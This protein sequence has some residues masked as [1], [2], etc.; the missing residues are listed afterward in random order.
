M[1]LRLGK[2][3]IRLTCAE[4]S[5]DHPGLEMIYLLGTFGTV[6]NG[7][8]VS[9]T[10]APQCLKFGDWC[11]Q[12]LAFYSGNASYSQ[13]IQPSLKAGERLF[14]QIPKYEGVALR[15]WVNGK[16]ARIIGW[17]PNEADITDLLEGQSS[18]LRIE[19]IGHRRNSHGPFNVKSNHLNWT[20]PG[21][22]MLKGTAEHYVGYQRVPCGLMAAP[23]LSVR[24]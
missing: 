16:V 12:G 7:T 5:E 17:E 22:Y 2:N 9:M 8:A 3:E 19:V 24:R 18:E 13:M 6:V 11:D 20:G 15:V 21:D 14:V 23:I 4:Y 10:E 1:L